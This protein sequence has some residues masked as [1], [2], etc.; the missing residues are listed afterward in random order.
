MNID[1]YDDAKYWK[2]KEDDETDSGMSMDDDTDERTDD[3][4][5]SGTTNERTD[6]DTD[7]ETDIMD[8][9]TSSALDYVY[10]Y[11]IHPRKSTLP[12][13]SGAASDDINKYIQSLSLKH[14]FLKDY[15]YL[16]YQYF[17]SKYFAD[18]Q[19]L[20]LWMTVGSGKTLLSIS[21]GIAGL[22]TGMFNKVII[23]SPK[24]IQD[25]FRKNLVLYCTLSS[26]EGTKEK[27]ITAMY[28]KY[29]TCFHLI[30]YNSSK[31][32][33]NFH[34]IRDLE[35]SLFIID[36]A[37]LF[38]KAIMKVNLMKSD[39]T[40]SNLKNKGNAKRIYDSIKRLFHKKI[41][42]LTGTPSSKM[43]FEMVPL[44]N[45]AYRI[46]LFTTNM[47]EWNNYYIDSDEAEVLHK[48]E[49]IFR[50]N[51][52]IAYVPRPMTATSVKASPLEMVFVEMGYDQYK[53]Y[54][55]DYKKELDEIGHNPFMNMYGY[56]FG[57]IS[58]YHTKTFEDCIY[59]NKYLT[60]KDKEDRYV[61]GSHVVN[62][63]HCPKIIQMYKDTV[64]IPGSCVFYFRF[65]G[66]YGIES[67]A[68]LLE[69]NGYH[70]I[71]PRENIFD[72]GEAKRFAIFSGDITMKCRNKWK[73]WFNDKRNSKGKYIKYLLLSPSG[74]VG[75]TLK[76]VRYLGIGNVDFVYAT[77]R[78]I[79]GRVNRLGSHDDLP[80]KDRTLINK[81]YIMQKNEQY[82]NENVAA[83]TE[84]CSREA[85]GVEETAPTIERII[86]ADSI[87]DDDINEDFKEN[88]L[89]PA[90]ITEKVYDKFSTE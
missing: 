20:V 50:L 27:D 89:I 65:T 47:E 37:H 80:K 54:L 38:T 32:S 14:P 42:A 73:D 33:R 31:A 84:L 30:A 39:M 17:L 23:L 7:D 34:E 45:L 86:L 3:D 83:V 29:M 85:P 6:D 69:L 40:K 66:I 24:S 1:E 2:D 81:I 49:L 26:P 46:D 13:L 5:E 15:Q 35:H 75:I 44:W 68:R 53:Q 82:F 79:M 59:W 43:P 77:I 72:E 22:K 78:Q 21:C 88:V 16:I 60:N 90:S 64:D 52:L 67:M 18:K 63:K 62:S 41:L 58:S 36:E 74:S 51:G 55:I 28:D 8:E 56:K 57:K 19:L 87:H 4:G 11:F 9:S 71:E 12:S 61:G 76:N 10:H 70:R 25:E 48:E